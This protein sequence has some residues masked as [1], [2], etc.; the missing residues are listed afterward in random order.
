MITVTRTHYIFWKNKFCIDKSG[1][2]TIS[3]TSI[4]ILKTTSIAFKTELPYFFHV[5]TNKQRAK[6]GKSRSSAEIDTTSE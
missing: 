5:H 4:Y 6:I 2:A 3:R 1:R